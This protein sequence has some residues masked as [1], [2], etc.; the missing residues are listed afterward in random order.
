VDFFFHLKEPQRRELENFWRQ[1]SLKDSEKA[2]IILL[3]ADGKSV[4][5]IATM[6]RRN[7]HTTRLW[8]RRYSQMGISGL[9]REY[10]A[11]RPWYK[12]ESVKAH[13][14]ESLPHSPQWYGYMDDVWTVPLISHALRKTRNIDASK[15]TITRALKEMGYTYKRPSKCPAGEI[16]HEE[17]IMAINRIS[18]KIKELIKQKDCVIYDLNESHFSTEPYLVRGWF[19]KRWSPPDRNT[20]KERKSHVLWMLESQ[21]IKISLEEVKHL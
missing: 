6:L 19:F 21:N 9:S 1:A 15:D 5:N 14:K 12:K 17:K 20:H 11:G 13:I 8:L 4:L 2:L 7:P 18:E 10:S 16:I 3:N